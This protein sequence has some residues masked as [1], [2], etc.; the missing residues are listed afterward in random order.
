MSENI[1]SDV[2]LARECI[3][4]RKCLKDVRA[5]LRNAGI[6]EPTGVGETTMTWSEKLDAIDRIIQAALSAKAGGG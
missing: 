3:R 4:L 2:T 1:I 5:V 6:H